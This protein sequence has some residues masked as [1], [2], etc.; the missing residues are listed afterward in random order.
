M[1]RYLYNLLQ[2]RI[3]NLNA[4]IKSGALSKRQEQQLRRYIRGLELERDNSARN[5]Y[6]IIV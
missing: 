5:Q 3:D 2:K 4:S 6:G 1:D